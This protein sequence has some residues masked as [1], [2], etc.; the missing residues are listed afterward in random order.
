L[1]PAG[2]AR[3]PFWTARNDWCSIKPVS[4]C[5]IFLSFPEIVSLLLALGDIFQGSTFLPGQTLNSV[6]VH[7][8]ENFVNSFLIVVFRFEK[9]APF[10][11]ILFLSQ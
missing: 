10:C 11:I 7:L 9:L 4:L 1:L 3:R 6:F 2:Q 8:I 5:F